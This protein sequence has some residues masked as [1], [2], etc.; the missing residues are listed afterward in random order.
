V[1]ELGL[2]GPMVPAIAAALW[3]VRRSRR[4]EPAMI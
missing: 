3:L 2:L 1:V 4:V